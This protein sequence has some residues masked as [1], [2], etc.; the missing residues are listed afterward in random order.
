ME[1]MTISW[2]VARL[3]LDG[4]IPSQIATELNNY[5]ESNGCTVL[6]EVSGV[7]A[8]LDDCEPEEVFDVQIDPV[9]G[10]PKEFFRGYLIASGHPEFISGEIT[11]KDYAFGANL[12]GRLYV[13]VRRFQQGLCS[14]ITCDENAMFL[15]DIYLPAQILYVPLHEH[16]GSVINKMSGS[17]KAALLLA[18]Y[19]ARNS[20]HFRNGRKLNA[21]KFAALVTSLQASYAESLGINDTGLKKFNDTLN[22]LMQQLSLSDH[23]VESLPDVHPEGSPLKTLP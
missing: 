2:L 15:E 21:S 8:C 18:F 6:A 22:S 3:K 17:D 10:E 16:R 14:Y 5:I 11:L 1:K 4:R 7:T 23:P 13:G 12:D 9:T 19:L 20:D